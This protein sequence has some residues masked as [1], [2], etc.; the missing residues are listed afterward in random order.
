MSQVEEAEENFDHKER[1][2][3]KAQIVGRRGTARPTNV[4]VGRCCRDAH[5]CSCG[6]PSVVK[7]SR[8]RPVSR[9][10]SPTCNLGRMNVDDAAICSQARLTAIE[11]DYLKW[12]FT[13][14]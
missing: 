1:I 3:R 10:L 5:S 7:L 13:W 4:G 9:N 6:F 12:R 11:T 8:A 2:E 14:D